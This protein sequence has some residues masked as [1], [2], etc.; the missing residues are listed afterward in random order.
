MDDLTY[1]K[2]LLEK[3]LITEE[4]YNKIVKRSQ[5]VKDPVEYKEGT[6]G[7]VLKE[8]DEWLNKITNSET[9]KA[10]YLSVIK[11]FLGYLYNE[12]AKKISGHKFKSFTVSDINKYLLSLF[13]TTKT[14]SGIVKAGLALPKF[15]DFLNEKYHWDIDK[16]EIFDAKLTASTLMRRKR[17]VKYL[18][19]D[20]VYTMADN[21]DEKCAALIL[22]SYE[23]C[24]KRSELLNMRISDIDFN[25]CK[26]SVRNSEGKVTRTI[27]GSKEL[28]KALRAYLNV[29]DEDIE[30]SNKRREKAGEP[31]R[32]KSDYLLQSRRAE[33]GTHYYIDY[34]LKS[35]IGAYLKK[36]GADNNKVKETVF[37]YKTDNLRQCRILYYYRK[38]YSQKKID[39]LTGG[40]NQMQIK[41]YKAQLRKTLVENT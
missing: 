30:K 33:T 38:K 32:Q 19:S 6:A 35:G 31:L 7:Y 20:E 15:I 4:G 28:F 21:V 1:A 37:Q 26:F 12:N 18:S 2:E 40:L 16:N 9:S 25:E 29:L 8:F 39:E 17:E 13:D 34:I 27:Y 11:N 22:I 41:N 24:L 14:S 3:N 23:G 36:Q 5:K 10:T